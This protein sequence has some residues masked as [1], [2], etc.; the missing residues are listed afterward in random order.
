MTCL[1]LVTRVH[2]VACRRCPSRRVREVSFALVDAHSRL[3][4]ALWVGH[5][6]AS[7]C[8]RLQ[9]VLHSTECAGALVVGR[10]TSPSNGASF[11]RV[12]GAQPMLLH[13][14]TQHQVEE[15]RITR[16]KKGTMNKGRPPFCHHQCSRTAARPR[17]A[18]PRC[19][20]QST[21]Y[22]PTT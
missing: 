21:T 12:L 20:V 7:R 6:A 11:R 17:A 22:V 9:V 8:R 10:G 1:V 3:L 16:C 13:T 14:A 2:A 18:L 5:C 19:N 15:S 4:S